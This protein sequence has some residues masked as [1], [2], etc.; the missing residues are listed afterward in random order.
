MYCDAME[1]AAVMSIVG[2]GRAAIVW[3]CAREAGS[4]EP[5]LSIAI[6][7][8]Y[9]ANNLFICFLAER[10]RSPD[11]AP[12]AAYGA[13]PCSLR[14]LFGVQLT[15]KFIKP[16]FCERFTLEPLWTEFVSFLDIVL[17]LEGVYRFCQFGQS[18]VGK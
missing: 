6:V 7:S 18:G 10:Q 9:M 2:I 13:T 16:F 4:R 17:R 1:T 3:P 14:S 8:E 5:P 11:A 15:E 12:C